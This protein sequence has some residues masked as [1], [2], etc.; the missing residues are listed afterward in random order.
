MFLVEVIEAPNQPSTFVKSV[1]EIVASK[2]Y[3]CPLFNVNVIK[4]LVIPIGSAP[5]LNLQF[6]S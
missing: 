1:E 3:V 6:G 2:T 4:S 5:S